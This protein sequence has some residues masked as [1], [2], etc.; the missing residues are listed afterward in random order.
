M[1]GK[2]KV[3]MFV[4]SDFSDLLNIF[5]ANGVKYLII[6]GYAVIQYTEPR[7]TKD[8]DIWIGVEKANA[9]AIYKSSGRHQDFLDVDSLLHF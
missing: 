1:R 3:R 7:F 8:L 2:S 4:N 5:H 6:G 9:A